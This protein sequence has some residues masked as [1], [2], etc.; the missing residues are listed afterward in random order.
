MQAIE[1]WLAGRP[2][3]ESQPLPLPLGVMPDLF[4][5]FGARA[6]EAHISEDDIPELGQLGYLGNR[7]PSFKAAWAGAPILDIETIHVEEAAA[8][9]ASLLATEWI[10]LGSSEQQGDNAD[11]RR[12]NQEQ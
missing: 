12:K 5:G 3:P 2:R 10:A 9:A 4:R 6:D 8:C 1:L 7:K 11:D